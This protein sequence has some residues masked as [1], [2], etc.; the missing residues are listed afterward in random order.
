MWRDCYIFFFKKR[1]IDGSYAAGRLMR[2]RVEGRWEYRHPTEQE[3]HEIFI[4]E[5]W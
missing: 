3:T 4:S 1:L 5:A 2:R